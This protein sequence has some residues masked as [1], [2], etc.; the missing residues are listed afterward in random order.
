MKAWW[1][2]ELTDVTAKITIYHTFIDGEPNVP[3]H[4]TCPRK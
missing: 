1:Q 2:P 3:K 4:R